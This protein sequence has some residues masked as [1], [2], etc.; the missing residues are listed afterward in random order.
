MLYRLTVPAAPAARPG[1]AA[2]LRRAWA[3][4]RD[5]VL[6]FVERDRQRRQAAAFRDELRGLDDHMLRD[7]GFDRS[8]IESVAAEATGAAETTRARAWLMSQP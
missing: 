8:E 7:L 6:A 1:F 2:A 4:A 3:G 5:A